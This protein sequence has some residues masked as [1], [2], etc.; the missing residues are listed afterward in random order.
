MDIQD[1][2]NQSLQG[3]TGRYY[4]ALYYQGTFSGH[5]IRLQPYGQEKP[6]L[7]LLLLFL[8]FSI[9]LLNFQKF[10]Q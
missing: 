1:L 9:L 3:A 4:A 8:Y 5:I 10:L 2:Y 7:L 6:N